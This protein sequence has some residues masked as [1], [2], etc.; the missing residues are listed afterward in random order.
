MTALPATMHRVLIV[1]DE[2]IIAEDLR[3][4]LEW[5]GYGIFGVVR[6]GDAAIEAM[7]D[8]TPDL[9]LMDIRI[10]GQ[11]DGI[12]TARELQARASVPIIYLTSHSDETTL[13]RAKTTAPHGYLLKPFSDRDLRTAIEVALAK[14]SVERRLA[15]RERWFATTLRSIGDAVITI[16]RERCVTFMNEAAER[17][18]GMLSSQVVGAPLALSLGV[19]EPSGKGECPVDRAMR[20][21]AVIVVSWQGV[22]AETGAPITYEGTVAP[23]L[24]ADRV[25]LGAVMVLRG[26]RMREVLGEEG[27]K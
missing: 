5:L 13:A 3:Q 22:L 27:A 16:D 20:E 15:E 12:D 24:D 7:K 14:H 9:V 26:A 8:A 4:T 23:L 18:T 11:M 21:R 1:E 10:R 19:E 25:L 2:A 17:L 6:S